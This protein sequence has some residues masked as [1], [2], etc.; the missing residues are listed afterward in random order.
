MSRAHEEFLRFERICLGRNACHGWL[1]EVVGRVGSSSERRSRRRS[2][3]GLR[4]VGVAG[5]N[6][7]KTSRS[8]LVSSWTQRRETHL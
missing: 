6:R 7:G 3:D 1:R 2:K 5:E 8:V 4:P